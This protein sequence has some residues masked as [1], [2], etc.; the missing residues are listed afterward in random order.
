MMS[1]RPSPPSAHD[2][3]R[4]AGVSQ[5]AVSRAYTPGASIAATTRDRVLQAAQALGYRPNLLARS[6]IKGES[7]IIGVVIG[8]PR[9]PFFLEALAALSARMSH[10]GKHILVYTAQG[11]TTVDVLVEDLLQYRVDALFLMAAGL[12]ARLATQ[13]RN[14]G[15]PVVSF[16]V[17]GF[18][19]V[20]GD[21]VRGGARIAEHFIAQGYRN[22][23]F[24][25]GAE[26]STTSRERETGFTDHLAARGFA[27]PRRVVGRFRRE[28]AADAVRG[29]LKAGA[30][31]D[32]I[33][34]ANDHMAIAA[35]EVAR[36]E[37]GLEPG[38]DLGIA[39]FDDIEQAA[40]PSFDLTTYSLPV[41][42]LI[43]QVA[44]LL[45]EPAEA[46]EPTRIVIA[47]EL[48]ARGSTRRA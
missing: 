27:P 30:R 9:Y 31:P 17:P 35:I 38:R 12:S 13:C 42:D 5:A 43:E 2:V 14:A 46:A 11:D 20:N 47:G 36:F 37:F 15:V 34:C 3:A 7:G 41:E 22:F 44:T 33:F 26:G 45:L 28:T 24:V 1:K 32:A 23:A 16:N 48:K 21:H 10:A 39:G 19:S 25:A 6:L 18:A 4:L 29:L 40:W 8:A